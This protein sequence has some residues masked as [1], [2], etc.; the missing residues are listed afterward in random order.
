MKIRFIFQLS[1]QLYWQL[2]L[3]LWLCS[4]TLIA[5][6]QTDEKGFVPLF[7]GKSLKGWQLIKGQGPG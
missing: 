5:L 4:L 6:A 1:W 2:S 3:F 7:D